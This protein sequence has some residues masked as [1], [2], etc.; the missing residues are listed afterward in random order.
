[1][2]TREPRPAKR[3]RPP[4]QDAVDELQR[5]WY[6]AVVGPV[7]RSLVPLVDGLARFLVVL[8]RWWEER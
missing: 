1:M 7:M 6:E 2:N 3:P 4:L 5:A 8:A